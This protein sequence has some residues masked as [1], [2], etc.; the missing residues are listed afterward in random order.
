[1]CSS[2]MYLVKT[3]PLAEE[4]QHKFN[5]N[6]SAIYKLY[7]IGVYFI[8]VLPSRIRKKKATKDIISLTPWFSTRGNLAPQKTSGSACRHFW[9]SH[10]GKEKGIATAI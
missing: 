2:Y 1:M 7:S 5:F 10:W 8:K 3:T 4:I 9:L 6:F